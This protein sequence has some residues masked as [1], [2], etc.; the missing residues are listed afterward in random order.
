MTYYFMYNDNVISDSFLVTS[1]K[2]SLLPSKDIQTLEVMSR[3]GKIFNG[4]KYA[5]LEYTIQILVQGETEANLRIQLRALKDLLSSKSIVKMATRPDRYGYGIITD[6][7]TMDEKTNVDVLCTIKITCYIPYFY[8]TEE[9]LFT[10]LK[11]LKTMQVQNKG[12]MATKPFVTVGF[13][14]QANFFQLQ[15]VTTNQTLLLGKYP[16][17]EKDTINES[18]EVLYD[19]CTTTSNWTTSTLP[20]DDNR[21][22]GGTLGVTSQTSGL[23]IGSLPTSTSTTKWKG[24]EVRRNLKSAQDEFKMTAEITFKS[25]GTNGDPTVIPSDEETGSVGTT[26]TYYVVNTSTLNVRKLP[27]TSSQIMGTLNRGYELRGGSLTN[28]WLAFVDTNIDSS[29]GTLYVSA[30]YLKAKTETTTVSTTKRNVVVNHATMLQASPTCDSTV[31]V[32]IPKDAVLRIYSD[33]V[34]TSY[35]SDNKQRQ[36]YKLATPY[37]GYMGWVCRGNLY[38]WNAGDPVTKIEY[39]REL[40]TADDKTGTF[41]IY[42]MGINNERIFKV[43]L[44]DDNEYYEFNQPSITVGV[45]H[46]LFKDST[47]APAPKSYKTESNGQVKYTNYLSGVYGSWNDFYGH[48]SIERTKNSD[49]NYTWTYNISKLWNGSVILNKKGSLKIP[50]VATEKLAYIILYM[51]TYSSIAKCTDMALNSIK[52]TGK[53]TNFDTNV[54]TIAFQKG[55]ILDIDFENRN[56]YIN[57]EQRND[58]VDIGS[59]YFDIVKGD[60]QIKIFSNDEQA[61]VGLALNEKWVGEE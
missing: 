18:N 58:L 7:I 60:N 52:I 43:Q 44:W 53:D 46:I 55:D 45:N 4:S 11:S 12:G 32:N 22:V 17:I 1:I 40:E 3:D 15:N 38:S 33:H 29:G 54:D 34:E 36:W 9:C 6:E 50:N 57:H 30:A 8:S 31:L 24:V 21:T 16:S 14:T 41:E 23:C 61:I 56:V 20:I 13:N 28:G 2:R 47:I 27:T 48:I 26:S 42:G 5:P 51:G 49:G 19:T 25:T 59:E 39:D 35:D 10:N 37:K